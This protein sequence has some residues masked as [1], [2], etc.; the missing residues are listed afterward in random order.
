MEYNE[1]E[2]MVGEPAAPYYT[3]SDISALRSQIISYVETQEDMNVLNNVFVFLKGETK[4]Q[5]NEK[6]SRAR[7]FALEHY[8]AERIAYLE[9]RNYFVGQPMPIHVCNSEE[10]LDEAIGEARKEFEQ[11][12]GLPHE[13][14][15]CEIDKMLMCFRAVNYKDSRHA[16][17]MERH[18]D[19]GNAA[20]TSFVLNENL[21]SRR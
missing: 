20:A 10:A 18:G 6:V 9:E 7:K 21:G 3:V 8:D 17:G 4:R 13:Q 14:M 15:M 2:S 16:S 5:F 1:N 12:G 19:Y 11:K